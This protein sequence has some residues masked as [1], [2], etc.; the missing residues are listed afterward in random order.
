MACRL[1]YNRWD[2]AAVNYKKTNGKKKISNNILCFLYSLDVC[3]LYCFATF[4][5]TLIYVCILRM[6][7]MYV[8]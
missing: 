1:L 8:L 2:N 6:Y 3:A 7:S 4:T 5:C